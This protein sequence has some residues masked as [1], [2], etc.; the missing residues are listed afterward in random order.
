MIAGVDGYKGGW[1]AAIRGNDSKTHFECFPTF[2][3]LAKRT[4]LDLMVI[5]I[6][7]GLPQPGTSRRADVEARKLLGLRGCCVFSAP[8]RGLLDCDTYDQASK[9][10][11]D[12]E[13]KGLSTQAWSIVRKVKEVDGLMRTDA[14][15]KPRVKEGRSEVTFAVMNGDEPIPVSKHASEG[16]RI[17]LEL[18]QEWF[19]DQPRDDAHAKPGARGDIIDAYALLWTAR[20]FLNDS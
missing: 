4:D 15:V 17:R 14:G 18:L 9:E 6:P 2:S 7:I 16:Q 3:D 19:G 10:R 1:I 13:E 20:R 5:D 12:L 11:H 8:L